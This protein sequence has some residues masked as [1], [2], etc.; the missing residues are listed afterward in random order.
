M[1]GVLG[2]Q[3]GPDWT[4]IATDLLDVRLFDAGP[5]VSLWRVAHCAHEALGSQACTVALVDLTEGRLRTVACDGIDPAFTQSMVGRTVAIEASGALDGGVVA[6]AAVRE[7]YSL[8]SSGQGAASPE[9][10]R[11]YGLQALLSHPLLNADGTLLGYLNHF[12]STDEP[13]TSTTK[14][15]L[16]TFASFAVATI[17]RSD[18]QRTFEDSVKG[19]GQLSKNLLV[20]AEDSF[21]K[22][23]AENAV[24]LLS[25][26]ACI[27]WQADQ[28]GHQLKG[29]RYR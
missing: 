18:L 24:T 20:V 25:A 16:A 11:R 28:N 4:R 3:V 21:L 15:I 2:G 22:Q 8:P 9:I 7:F 14:E 6:Q 5:D 13:F 23:V 12:A 1:T 17:V 29:G 10:A 26:N 19:L 27:V